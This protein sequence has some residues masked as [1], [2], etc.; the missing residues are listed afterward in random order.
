METEYIVA[1]IIIGYIV[2][3]FFAFRWIFK[4]GGQF[5]KLRNESLEK[6]KKAKTRE[7]LD[8]AWNV[9]YLASQY[10]VNPRM[11]TEIRVVKELLIYKYEQ[12]EEQPT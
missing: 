9:L 7:E 5:W 10:A 11:R 6:A 2:L 3:M 8:E 1:S 4:I 12:L